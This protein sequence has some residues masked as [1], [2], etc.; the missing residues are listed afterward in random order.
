[1]L[2]RAAQ[3][4]AASRWQATDSF[5]VLRGGFL[6]HPQFLGG[7]H[8]RDGVI[9][10]CAN[11]VLE[12]QR[13]LGHRNHT[14]IDSTNHQVMSRAISDPGLLVGLDPVSLLCPHLGKTP[15]GLRHDAGQITFDKTCMPT[16]QHDL[17]EE[18]QVVADEHLAIRLR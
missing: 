4:L 16:G 17:T 3:P 10:F 1:M 11:P 2:L 6:G 9:R 12:H 5:S 8:G 13:Q 14:T 15:N 7:Q 18:A